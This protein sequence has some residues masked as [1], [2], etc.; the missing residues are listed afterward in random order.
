[1]G[2]TLSA[3]GGIQS[4][5]PNLLGVNVKRVSARPF[6]R[7]A[8]RFDQLD[9]RL[10]VADARHVVEVN[11]LVREKRGGDDR[12]RRVLVSGR[13]NGAL[14]LGATLDDVLYCGHEAPRC[15]IAWRDRTDVLRKYIAQ[16]TLC[17]ARPA[18]LKVA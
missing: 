16:T 6:D 17:T 11:R 8:D 5:R 18:T 14:Q 10:D 7:R 2:W 13:A 15:G 3:W 9:E 12:Q 1:R 4:L